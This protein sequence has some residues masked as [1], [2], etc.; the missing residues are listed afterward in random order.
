MLYAAVIGVPAYFNDAQREATVRAAQLAGIE[1]VKLIREPEAAALAYRNVSKTSSSFFG[2][3]NQENDSNND[4][5]ELIIVF[6]LGGGTYDVSALVMDGDLCTVLCTSG[7]ARLGGTNWD[8]RIARH[9][10]QILRELEQQQEGG[11]TRAKDWSPGARNAVLLAAERARIHLSNNRLVRLA[12]P[13]TEQGWEKLTNPQIVLLPPSEE[14]DSTSSSEA[15]NNNATHVFL[16]MN[17]R[18]MESLC[19]EEFQALLRPLREVAIM[20]GAMLPGDASPTLVDNAFKAE[21][22][23]QSGGGDWYEDFY[24]TSEA[25]AAVGPGDDASL[26]RELEDL[27]LRHSKKAQQGGRKKARDVAKQERRFR[28]EKRKLPAIS[29]ENAKVRDG[30]SGR[31]ISRVVLVGGATRMPGVGRLIAALTG[32]APQRTINPDEAVALGCAVQVGVLDGS[33]QFGKVLNPMQAAILRAMAEQSQ[34]FDDDDNDE[35]D[36]F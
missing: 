7:D 13:R 8:D 18:E 25:T 20:A 14:K 2:S 30:I 33:E 31:P 10:F 5:D 36:D 19:R 16:T 34:M 32:V 21:A 28:A 1:K 26:R 27:V 11:S 15:G 6:D 22:A 9:W 24:S 4:V 12:L 17:R 35:N 23:F 3:L 29:A